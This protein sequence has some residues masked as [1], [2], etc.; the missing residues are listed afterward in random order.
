MEIKQET[1][2]TYQLGDTVI[3]HHQEWI[4]AEDHNGDVLLYRDSVDGHS[5]TM[6]FSKKDLPL[7]DEFK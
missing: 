6:R 5:R 2:D 1:T 7:K 3:I 4:I